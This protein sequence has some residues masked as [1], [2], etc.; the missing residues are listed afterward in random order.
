MAGGGESML[1]IGKALGHVD[2]G[3]TAVYARL[4]LDP[5]RRAME[6]ATTAML[7]NDKKQ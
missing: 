4:D 1:I 3:S 5:V 6:K 2:G 7:K